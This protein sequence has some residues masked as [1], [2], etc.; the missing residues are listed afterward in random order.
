MMKHSH[1]NIID[2]LNREKC[3]CVIESVNGEIYI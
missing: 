1:Q 2:I 3:S